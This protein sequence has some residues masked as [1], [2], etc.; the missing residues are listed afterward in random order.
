[1]YFS[2]I[3]RTDPGSDLHDQRV[4]REGPEPEL[5]RGGNQRQE[6]PEE[7]LPCR[8]GRLGDHLWVHRHHVDVRQERSLGL[9]CM[10]CVQQPIYTI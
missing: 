1:M 2:G 9:I 5:Q 3:E 6:G 4:L 10:Y 7:L 8:Q